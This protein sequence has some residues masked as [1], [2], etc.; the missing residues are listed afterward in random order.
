M[1]LLDSN[2]IIYSTKAE[3]AFLKNLIQSNTHS[4]SV[5]T[6]IEC[7]GFH[8]LTDRDLHY[9]NLVFDYFVDIIPIDDYIA[10]RAIRLKQSNKM[11]LADGIIG[12]TAYQYGLELITRSTKD[13]KHIPD[14]KITNPIDKEL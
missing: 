10:D 8:N 9:L 3:Y 14:L 2:I 13:F 1:A 5:I 11:E 6:K 12:A 7:L 4:V